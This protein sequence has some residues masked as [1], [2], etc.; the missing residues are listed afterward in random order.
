MEPPLSRRCPIL[1][2]LKKL[3]DWISVKG[4]TPPSRKLLGSVKSV[5]QR[6]PPVITKSARGA[7]DRLLKIAHFELGHCFRKQ[8]STARLMGTHR[9]LGP[10]RETGCG[11]SDR[12]SALGHSRRFDRLPTTS[13]RPPET[14]IVTGRCP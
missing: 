7:D 3:T 6:N 9:D 12:R 5:R 2:T 1:L 8:A 14:D 10:I 11:W 4:K 13:G